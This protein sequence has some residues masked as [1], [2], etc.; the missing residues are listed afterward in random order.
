MKTALAVA[1]VLLVSTTARAQQEAVECRPA[2]AKTLFPLFL[3]CDL[4]DEFLT[5]NVDPRTVIWFDTPVSRDGAIA[6]TE[7]ENE[8]IQRVPLV[9]VAA[10]RN[11]TV[12]EGIETR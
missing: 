7:A 4:K 6:R 1:L 12:R 3:T 11:Q 2:T 5:P 9:R 8:R 10:I